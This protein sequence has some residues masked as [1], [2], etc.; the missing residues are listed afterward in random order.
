MID[1]KR[2]FTEN[3]NLQSMH[4][5]NITEKYKDFSHTI[6]LNNLKGP[7]SLKNVRYVQHKKQFLHPSVIKSS[8]STFRNFLLKL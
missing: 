6:M 7:S 4:P 5:K 1:A 2:V 8:R 3:Q